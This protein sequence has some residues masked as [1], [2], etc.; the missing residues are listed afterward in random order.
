MF[1]CLAIN[2]SLKFLIQ[3][4]LCKMG[5]HSN[6]LSILLSLVGI[7][8]ILIKKKKRKKNYISSLIKRVH[9]QGFR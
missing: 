9:Y 3:K 7:D 4:N 5:L 6:S 1:I 2:K 8:L